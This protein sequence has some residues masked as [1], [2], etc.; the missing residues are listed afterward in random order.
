M[1]PDPVVNRCALAASH[2][3]SS[4]AKQNIVRKAN[5]PRDMS[6][7]HASQHTREVEQQHT[8]GFS[9]ALNES[10][11]TPYPRPEQELIPGAAGQEAVLTRSENKHT[12][13]CCSFK[14]GY[15][16]TSYC[17]VKTLPDVL[18]WGGG[19]AAVATSG[20]FFSELVCR[21]GAQLRLGSAEAIFSGSGKHRG[22]R[23]SESSVILQFL[24]IKIC[25]PRSLF[26]FH[27]E[28]G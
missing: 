2:R 9:A 3:M 19:G 15:L 23:G 22:V 12:E 28:S 24:L 26:F 21:G 1:Q 6:S 7:P 16:G 17:L 18:Y 13:V 8:S 11:P 25:F 27:Q 14:N 10:P 20:P 5:G 4:P